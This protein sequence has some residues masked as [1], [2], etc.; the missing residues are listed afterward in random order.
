MQETNITVET[1]HTE[2]VEELLNLNNYDLVQTQRSLIAL[3][4]GVPAFMM[5]KVLAS[6]FYAKQNIK[7]PVKVGAVAMLINTIFCAALIYPLQH[8]GLAL[9]SA[10]AG[11]VNA[12]ALLTLLIRRKVFSP[13]DGWGKYF[14][15]VTC[16]NIA[17]GAYLFWGCGLSEIWMEFFI[18]KRISLLLLHVFAAMLIYALTL[19]LCGIRFSQ[20]RGK[21]SGG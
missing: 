13:S 15:Q 5:V 8:A 21:V 14:L 20:F 18:F 9:A 4:F 12:G 2:P 7:T 6:G 16:A 3:G 11:Y 19:G 10:L 17:M 1:L